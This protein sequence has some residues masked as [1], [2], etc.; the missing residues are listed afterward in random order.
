MASYDFTAGQGETFDRTVTWKIDDA[1]VNLTGYT[2]RMQIRKTHRSASSVVSLTQSSGL[3]L[4]GSAGTIRI[5]ISATATAALDDGKLRLRPRARLRKRNRDPRPRR[6]VFTDAGGHPMTDVTTTETIIVTEPDGTTVEV[7]G[8]RGPQGIPGADGADGAD[9]SVIYTTDNYPTYA[10]VP[11][12]NDGDRF[13]YLGTAVL[14]QRREGTWITEGTIGADRRASQWFISG[15]GGVT[16]YTDVATP[17]EG[18]CFL[19]PNSG[20]LFRYTS[21]AWAYGGAI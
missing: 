9:G 4:G 11:N 20:D 21:S 3:T 13:L 18:D 7:S 10:D 6:N 14:W 16:D 19:Y 12:P 2:A 1:A 15:I 8:L 17:V 5:V